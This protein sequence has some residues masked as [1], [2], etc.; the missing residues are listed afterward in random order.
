MSKF[1]E[2]VE[3]ELFGVEFFSVGSCEECEECRDGGDHEEFSWSECDSCGSRLGG[4]RHAAHGIIGRTMEFKGNLYH[5][6]VCS[7]CLMF[8]ANGDEPDPDEE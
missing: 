3:R 6:V 7:D 4:E 2:A 5:F 8:H 1:T